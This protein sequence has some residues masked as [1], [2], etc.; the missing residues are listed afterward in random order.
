M[1][2]WSSGGIVSG[3]LSWTSLLL[4]WGSWGPASWQMAA[5]CCQLPWGTCPRQKGIAR[6]VVNFF[7]G[8]S[9]LQIDWVVEWKQRNSMGW[10]LCQFKSK[11]TTGPPNHHC[12]THTWLDISSKKGVTTPVSLPQ[13]KEVAGFAT[14]IDIDSKPALIFNSMMVAMKTD[15]D[16]L[17]CGNDT[18]AKMKHWENVFDRTVAL[19]R[20]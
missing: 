18:S 16:G 15:I 12:W 19:Q 3:W 5:A 13:T 17:T 4:G 14:G 1:T 11:P 20:L 9:S 2:R 10:E 6:S 8:Q 7:W